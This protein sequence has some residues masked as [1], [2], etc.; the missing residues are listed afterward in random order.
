MSECRECGGLVLGEEVWRET[1]A[2]ARLTKEDRI[3]FLVISVAWQLPAL[4]MMVAR[5]WC[6]SPD[7][8][9]YRKHFASA[10][11]DMDRAMAWGRQE[12]EVIK[13]TEEF[14][15]GYEHR[16]PSAQAI[17]WALE[18]VIDPFVKEARRGLDGMGVYVLP[19]SEYTSPPWADIPF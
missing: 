6:A 17:R 10:G 18:H 8:E 5:A 7:D 15:T 13:H 3:D 14:R 12:I 11:V 9:Y 19:E 4:G 1:R 16:V 2:I